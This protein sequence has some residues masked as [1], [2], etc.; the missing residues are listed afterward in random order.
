MDK[1]CADSDPNKNAYE[2]PFVFTG[3]AN[4][5]PQFRQLLEMMSIGME[6]FRKQTKGGGKVVS[7][8]NKKRSMEFT[9]SSA[10][11]PEPRAS[12]KNWR[13]VIGGL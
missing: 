13:H 11:N 12:R 5:A 3:T 2:D 6:I 8:K 7:Q 1:L 9:P 4:E 10:K